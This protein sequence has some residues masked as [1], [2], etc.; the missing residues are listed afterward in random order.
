MPSHPKDKTTPHPI[1][2][3]KYQHLFREIA[4]PARTVLLQ[5]G[6]TARQ[7][8]FIRKGCIRMWFN[9]H[10]KDVSF[11]FFFEGEGVSSVESFRSD[12]PSRFSIETLEPCTL[13]VLSKKNF[14]RLMEELPGQKDMLIEILH[15]RVAH[16]MDLFLSRIKDSPEKRYA[17][18]LQKSP[19]IIQRIPQHHI[20]SY[21]GITPVSLS[22]IRNRRTS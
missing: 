12:Q 8:Y 7:A 13:L 1:D 20:A 17:D 22:R 15:Q 10:G 18:L 14:Q 5:E 9:N 21:L 3:E 2:W 16:Y 19:H 4:V 11:Q 6:Q